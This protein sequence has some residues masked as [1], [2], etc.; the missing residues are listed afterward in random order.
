M[1]NNKNLHKA[2]KEKN[3]EFHKD[4]KVNGKCPYF[5][6]IIKPLYNPL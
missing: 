1:P 2:K 3:D 6:I 5:R 4:L